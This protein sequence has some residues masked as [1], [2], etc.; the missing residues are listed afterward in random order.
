[1]IIR[2]VDIDE[3]VDHH[4]LNFLFIYLIHVSIHV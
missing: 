3:T 4:V 1:V 2:Y